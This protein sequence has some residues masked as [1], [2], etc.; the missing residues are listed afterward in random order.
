MNRIELLAPAKD[1]QKAKI[2]IM[3]GADAVYVGGKFYSLRSRASNF[4]LEDLKELAD[5]AKKYLAKVYVT[6]NIVFHDDDYQGIADYLTYLGKIGIDAA[7]VSIT[8]IA[9]SE[10]R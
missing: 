8:R 5:F 9:Q 4:S 6:V 7:A 10:D 2:A 3:Y 1:L